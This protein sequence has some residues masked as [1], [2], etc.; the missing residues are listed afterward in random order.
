MSMNVCAE[1]KLGTYT[2]TATGVPAMVGLIPIITK[3]KPVDM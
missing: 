3:T 2:K 1:L